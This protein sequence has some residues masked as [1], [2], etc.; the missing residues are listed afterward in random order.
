MKAERL[1][2][3]FKYICVPLP[4]FSLM[5]PHAVCVPFQY[6]G[7]AADPEAL[8]AVVQTARGTSPS[9]LPSP[10]LV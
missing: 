5:P 8:A 1:L 4:P 10:P 2:S 9:L 3:T 6:Q 7:T